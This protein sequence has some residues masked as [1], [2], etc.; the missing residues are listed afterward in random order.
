M[1]PKIAPTAAM[2]AAATA[3]VAGPVSAQQESTNLVETSTDWSIFVEDDPT[4]CWG[5]APPAEQVNTRG[6]ERVSVTRG[7]TLLMVSYIPSQN[8]D[9]QVSWTGGYPLAPGRSVTVTIGDTTVEM[10]TVEGEWAWADS[11]EDDARLIEAMKRG[12]NAVVTA[13]SSRGTDTRDTF[14][15]MGFTAAVEEA[16]SRCGG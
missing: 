4:S 7:E 6:G 15:L 1:I 5:V 12:V 3:M 13:R 10:T 16:D 9:G 8:V 14:S 2:I 11:P